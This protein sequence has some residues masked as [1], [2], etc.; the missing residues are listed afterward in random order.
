[1][2]L[3][4]WKPA[5]SPAGEDA[6]MSTAS[7]AC[8][9]TCWEARH[10]TCVQASRRTR[11]PV[12]KPACG[13]PG[14]PVDVRVGNPASQPPG[15]PAD[16]RAVLPTRL[17]PVRFIWVPVA[18]LTCQPASRRMCRQISSLAWD[19]ARTPVC[20]RIERL[21]N[22]P[23]L[24]SVGTATGIRAGVPARMQTALRMD[25]QASS[26]TRASASRATGRRASGGTCYI[27]CV[28]TCG[29]AGK[30]AALSA[31]TQGRT[32]A[33]MKAF[34][35]ALMRVGASVHGHIPAGALAHTPV[36]ARVQAV[37]H[38]STPM[39]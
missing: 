1:M 33:R 12:S 31:W 38:A 25:G 17:S 11:R 3:R 28:L 30:Q 14:S 24:G 15:K 16:K 32:Q 19:C 34:G 26:R 36:K 7:P 5:G 29:P 20:P 21:A 35:D 6:R 13:W 37:T 18:P 9:C 27:A 4:M 8:G 22:E 10:G 39:Y 2:G 23:T